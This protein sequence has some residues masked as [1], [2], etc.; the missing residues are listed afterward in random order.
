MALIVRLIE[1]SVQFPPSGGKLHFRRLP[2]NGVVSQLTARRP[3]VASLGV[4]RWIDGLNGLNLLID[5]II[6]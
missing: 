6:D 4:H 3:Q 5:G 2:I 1:T